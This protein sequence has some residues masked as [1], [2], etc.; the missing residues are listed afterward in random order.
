MNIYDFGWEKFLKYIPAWNGLPVP[1]RRIFIERIEQQAVHCAGG[2]AEARALADA[3]FIRFCQDGGSVRLSTSLLL[4][5]RAVRAMARHP[6]FMPKS[7][8][9]AL[10][11]Y[12]RENFAHIECARLAGTIYSYGDVA[13]ALA[14]QTCRREW[15]DRFLSRGSVRDWENKFPELTRKPL[16][17]SREIFEQAKQ[18]LRLLME[19]E[20]PAIYAALASALAGGDALK[21]AGAIRALVQFGMLFPGLAERD[22]IPVI[23][24][25]PE[26]HRRIHRVKPP[27]PSSVRTKGE[28]FVSAFLMEDMTAVLVAGAAVPLRLRGNDRAIFSTA[29]KKLAEQLVSIPEGCLRHISYSPESRIEVGSRTLLMLN[30]AEIRRDKAGNFIL[31][32]TAAGHK[33]LAL[34]ARLRLGAILDRLLEDYARQFDPSDF[35]PARV[36]SFLHNSQ[37]M[38]CGGKAI[39]ARPAVIKAFAGLPQD[40]FVGFNRFMEHAKPEGNPWIEHQ[41]RGGQVT[42]GNFTWA[43][44]YTDEELEDLWGKLLKNFFIQRLFPLGGCAVGF[45]EAGELCLA[46][47]DAGRYL[48]DQTKTFEY[49]TET[50]TE[51]IV[52]PNF[53]VVFLLPS[54]IVEAAMLRFAERIG[55]GV[56]LMF[57]I[58]REAIHAAFAAGMSADQ[59][60]ECL[61]AVSKKSLP[62][63][64]EK[65]ITNWFAQC[66]RIVF[67]TSVLFRCP[68]KKT[69]LRVQAVAGGRLGAISD[70]ILELADPEKLPGIIKKL[71]QNGIASQAA[72]GIDSASPE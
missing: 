28:G 6:V 49:G 48:L 9:R 10:S 20:N 1:A 15:L 16:F 18:I 27:P 58:T 13:M 41:R 32:P 70:T 65:Q 21:L 62:G 2:M 17:H 36:M 35:A 29:K 23:G 54:P 19:G 45:T 30:F 22:Y 71:R 43:T 12:L 50:K 60:L 4:F 68:D 37:V 67:S 8:L 47:T 11:G 42:Q 24:I 34:S 59:V 14:R 53:E 66:R 26:I 5:R 51:V 33:W 7:D 57:R 3:G 39:D 63:N 61:R 72:A 69:A 38:W 46:L 25:W 31:A 52:Q 40:G 44:R 55:R 56:G 64:V